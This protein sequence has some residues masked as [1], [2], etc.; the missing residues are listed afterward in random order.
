MDT[1]LTS[2]FYKNNYYADV[3][4]PTA[5]ATVPGA[6]REEEIRTAHKSAFSS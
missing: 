4:M 1:I 6:E 2:V 5:V 3:I